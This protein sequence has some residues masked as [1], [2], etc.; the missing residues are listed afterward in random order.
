[1]NCWFGCSWQ[2]VFQM[3]RCMEFLSPVSSVWHPLR[4]S[5]VASLPHLLQALTG[6]HTALEW[7]PSTHFQSFSGFPQQAGWERWFIDCNHHV[8]L[9]QGEEAVTNN[10]GARL[11]D[12]SCVLQ[13]FFIW[14]TGSIKDAVNEL[15]RSY[16]T[17]LQMPE[18]LF[19]IPCHTQLVAKYIYL[20]LTRNNSYCEPPSHCYR[21]ATRNT[22]VPFPK[23]LHCWY[24]LTWSYCH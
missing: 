11:P 7:P 15:Y 24:Y 21:G 12:L 22:E 4:D 3:N 5:T 23:I 16:C 9:Y 2:F 8:Q 1:M 19:H 10:V 6:D 17:F 18:A 14:E 13:V 20:L